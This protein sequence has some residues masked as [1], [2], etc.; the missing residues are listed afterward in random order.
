MFGWSTHYVWHVFVLILSGGCQ[1]VIMPASMK[2]LS[3]WS[4]RL[5][6]LKIVIPFQRHI[7]F[8]FEMSVFNHSKSI[9]TTIWHANGIDFVA[10]F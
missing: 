10:F 7:F 5:N 9:L 1:S 3:T 2:A 6:F 4:E 8:F